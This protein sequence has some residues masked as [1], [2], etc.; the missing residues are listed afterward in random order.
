[1][2]YLIYCLGGLCLFLMACSN[3]LETVET[4]DDY[5]YAIKY[6]RSK[7]DYAKQGLYTKWDE[8]GQ[9]YEEANYKDDQLNGERKLYYENGQVQIVENYI[10]GS[11]E[12]PYQTFYENGQMEIDGQYVNNEASGEWKKYYDSSELMEIV[13]L[14]NNLENGPFVE[15]YRNGNKKAEGTYL[16]GD[17]EHG[18]LQMYN[19][20]GEL[21]KKMDC[22]R[23]VCRTTWEKPDAK[24]Q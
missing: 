23:G 3:G 10:N 9:K 2:R 24:E 22:K 13:Q 1:M 6:T 4:K 15:Y 21:V 14:K 7:K 17:N 11:F 12:G 19:Q 16:D 18:L 8:K 5:G 20:A